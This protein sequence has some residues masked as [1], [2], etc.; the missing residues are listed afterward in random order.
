M[1]PRGMKLQGMESR[2]CIKIQ[3]IKPMHKQILIQKG[4]LFV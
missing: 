2:D 4:M 3:V 1:G